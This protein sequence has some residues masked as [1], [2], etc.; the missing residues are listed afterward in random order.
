MNRI[1]IRIV[2]NHNI[3]I[4]ISSDEN[5]IPLYHITKNNLEMWK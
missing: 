2:P 5:M 3:E 1:T 4:S